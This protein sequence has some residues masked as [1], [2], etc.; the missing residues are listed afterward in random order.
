MTEVLEAPVELVPYDETWPTLFEQEAAVLRR[1]IDKWLAGP[2]EHVGSTAVPGLTAKPVIDIMAA[3]ESLGASRPAI[4][5]LGAINYCYFPYRADSMHWLCKPSPSYR[6]HHLHLVPFGSR[7]W[8]ERLA[9]RDY[10][11]AHADAS[12]EYAEL[13]RR[14]ATQHRFDREAYTDAKGPFVEHIVGL[15]RRANR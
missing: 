15:A 7:L 8:T 12:A 4:S 1:Q 10:L 6:T 2:I 9:F 11:R 3:V 13:K 5:V 14:L